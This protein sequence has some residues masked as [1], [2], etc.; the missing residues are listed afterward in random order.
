MIKRIKKTNETYT[1]PE[2]RKN[3]TWDHIP[4]Q[5]PQ[6]IYF[7]S[8]DYTKLVCWYFDVVEIRLEFQVAACSLVLFKCSIPKFLHLV[9]W[10][11]RREM[12]EELRPIDFRKTSDHSPNICLSWD[13]CGIEIFMARNLLYVQK[14]FCAYD[15][16]FLA[17]DRPELQ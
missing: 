12:T 5:V 11:C 17:T 13:I 10:F 16:D 7:S 6:P 2:T 14:V 15:M 1:K 9:K 3:Q 4:S 8:L